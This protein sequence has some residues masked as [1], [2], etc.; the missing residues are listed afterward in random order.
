MLFQDARVPQYPLKCYLPKGQL[1]GR[2]GSDSMHKKAEKAC[3]HRKNDKKDCIFD[4]IATRDVLV[5]AEGRIV[6][7][8]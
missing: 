8:Q 5:A 6:Q 2:L 7:L 3:A 1:S 4:V